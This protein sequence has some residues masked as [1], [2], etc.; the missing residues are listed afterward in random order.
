MS[1]KEYK[2]TLSKVGNSLQ[3]IEN[4]KLSYYT[5]YLEYFINLVTSYFVW[6]NLPETIDNRFIERNLYKNGHVCFYKDD[7]IG[8]TV[9]RGVFSHG[10]D[11][12]DNPTHYQFSMLKNNKKVKLCWYNDVFEE[13]NGII[14]GNNVSY[15]GIEHWLHLFAQKLA[16]I[17]A[18]IEINRLSQMT[19]YII[20]TD[21]EME[22]SV[23]QFLQKLYSHEPYIKVRKPKSVEQQPISELITILN[24]N[25][26]YLLD[27]LHDEKQRIINQFLTVIGINNNAVDKAERL[28]KAEATSNN[29]LIQASIQTMLETRQLACERINKMFGT[30]IS[31]KPSEYITMMNVEQT[32][33]LNVFDDIESE[34]YEYE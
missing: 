2:K 11:C 13:D 16:D 24:T 6:E 4:L 12:Y 22:L 29:A 10:L 31:V 8:L 17:E 25:A 1:L 33:E 9:Q 30:D 28:V 15:Q 19:P 26:P 14:I 20:L 34:P 18:T 3:N 5:F 32:N 21:E 23:Q 27:K 7:E